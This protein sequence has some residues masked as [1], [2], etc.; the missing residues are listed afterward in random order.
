MT[1]SFAEISEKTGLV[2]DSLEGSI[3]KMVQKKAITARINKKQGT[4]DF[5]ED[6]DNANDDSSSLV[7]QANYELI[8]TIEQ[9]NARIVKLLNRVQDTN[10]KIK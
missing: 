5:I 4:V 8:K 2:V 1:L 10:E 7:N 6:E 9:Q 3:T